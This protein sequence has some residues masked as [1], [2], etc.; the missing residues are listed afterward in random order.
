MSAALAQDAAA[1][2]PIDTG[3]TTW[4]LV[5]TAL[6]MLMTPGLA[7]FY[8]GMVSR[9]N[10]VSTLLQNYVAL[11]VVGL[12][13]IV[14]GFSLVFTEGSGFIGG[15]DWMM[16]KGL[17]TKVYEGANVPYY[18]FVAFQMMFAII[19]PA[20]ITG[21]I[22]ER[23]NFKAWLLIMVLWSLVVYVPVAHWVWGPGGWIAADGGIDFAGG[24]VVHIASGCSGLVAALMFGKRY[25][26]GHSIPNDVPMIMLGTALL[27]FGW[28]GFNAGSAI[29]SGTLAAHAFMTTFVGGATAFVA[30]MLTE[31][32]R[33]GKPTAVGSATGIVAGLVCITPA[34]G[35]VDITAAIIMTAIA[36]VV[37]N[38][39]AYQMKKQSRLDDALDVFACHGVGGIIGAVFTG[40][41]ASKAVNGALAVEGLAIS[42][43]TKLFVSNIVAVG[44]VC[45]YAVILTYLVIKLVNLV[46]PIKVSDETQSQ[47]LDTSLHGEFAKFNERQPGH[48]I[49]QTKGM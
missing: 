12:L 49:D 10:V 22:A 21:A 8:A 5:S 44:A 11:A 29:A 34:A 20:L 23:V 17:E 41:F 30:W 45:A 42:G 35:Y 33:S 25:K 37:C 7:F 13:W 32:V 4:L 24:L 39:I 38:M 46:M 6:V 31:W 9:K 47:G 14:A 16:L 18:A 19:T 3:N 15:L 48:T 28:F 26:T 27:W 43:E 2:P 36:G 1:P 40:V